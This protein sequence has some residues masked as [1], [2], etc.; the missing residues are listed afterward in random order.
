MRKKYEKKQKMSYSAQEDHFISSLQSTK[1]KLEKLRTQKAMEI[2][3]L[4]LKCG[5]GDF[6]EEELTVIFQN[7][8]SKPQKTS[9]IKDKSEA[10]TSL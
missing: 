6:S 2:G 7:L 8:A 5:I 3:K 9:L 4:A 10:K 1:V